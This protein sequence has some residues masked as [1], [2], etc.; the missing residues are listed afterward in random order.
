MTHAPGHRNADD[1]EAELEA[2]G[3]ADATLPKPLGI[4]VDEA[5]FPVSLPERTS[6]DR[7]RVLG[8]ELPFGHTVTTPVLPRYF[9]GDEWRPVRWSA[10]QI[11]DLQAK[12]VGAGL[13]EKG[14]TFLSGYWDDVSRAAYVR[15]LTFANR[16][17]QTATESI[18][19]Y[20]QLNA[21]AKA[22][23]KEEERRRLVVRRP[24]PDDLRATF[25]AVARRTVGRKLTDDEAASMVTAYMGISASYQN[26]V[27]AATETGGTVTE[28]P[29]PETFAEGQVREQS[30]TEAGTYDYIQAGNEFLGLLGDAG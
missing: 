9:E 2:G 3:V 27:F 13:I 5:G 12:L 16:T 26:Q 14:E 29:A 11:R 21:E 25:D 10:S 4:P 8:R 7:R 22:R 19:V 24:N 1:V 17:G 15:L 6:V 30:P 20:G 18:A 28:P 23:L